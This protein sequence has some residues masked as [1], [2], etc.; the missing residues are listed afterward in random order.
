MTNQEYRNIC[1]GKFVE[2]EDLYKN[3]FLSDIEKYRKG[4]YSITVTD[5]HGNPLKSK[6]IS[7]HQKNHD[8]KYGAN[9]FML[10]QFET[11][12]ENAAYR[13]M[14]YQYF[15][16]ATIPFYWDGLEPVM[17][18]PRFVVDS[19]KV[20]RRP[21]TDICLDYCEEHNI[22]PKLHCLFYDKWIPDWLPKN[23]ADEM[24]KLYEKRFAQISERYQGRMYEIEVINEI[25]EVPYWTTN[26]VL[27]KKRDIYRWAFKLAEKYFPKDILMSNEGCQIPNIAKHRFAHPYFLMLESAMLQGTRI[28]KIGIQNHVFCGATAEQD[29]D[30]EQY[31][32]YFDPMIQAMGLDILADLGKPLEITEVTVPTVGTGD[33]AEQLQAEL[34]KYLYTLWFSIPNMQSVVYWNTVEGTAYDSPNGKWRE[35]NCRGGLFRR[36]FTPKPAAVVLKNLFEKEWHTDL[37]LVTDTNGMVCFRG[38]YG[39]YVLLVDGREYEFSI[40]NGETDKTQIML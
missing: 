8:F 2:S 14:F 12:E 20:Y 4:S 38:F 7:I 27:S 15:N 40:H 29:I 18:Q 31:K 6:H 21:A 9:I 32:S 11:E 17:G 36:D 35:N 16:L 5:L 22:L 26:S 3:R 24:M 30:I 13:D 39:D 10:D 33:E 19:P 23:N 34:L 37:E 28:D 25:L 1:L